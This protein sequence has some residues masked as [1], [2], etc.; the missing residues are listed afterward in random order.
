MR[1]FWKRSGE[2]S[3][4][5]RELRANRATPTSKFV[6]SVAQRIY[7]GDR[8]WIRA[9]L[10]LLAAASAVLLVAVASVGGVSAGSNALGSALNVTLLSGNGGGNGGGN[11]NNNQG[12]NNN[13]GGNKC[14]DKKGKRSDCDQYEEEKKK[15]NKSE[16][17]RHNLAVSNE[18]QRHTNAQNSIKKLPK[19]QQ[20]SAT[21]REDATYSANKKDEDKKHGDNGKKCEKH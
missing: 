18:N 16:D 6:R 9:R 14:D 13:G 5:E 15:C 20:A 4:L 3:D 7:A 10:G 8:T 19:N 21:Q 11:G 1:R 17:E 12:G 2:F